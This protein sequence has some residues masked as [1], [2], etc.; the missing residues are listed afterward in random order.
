M[1]VCICNAVTTCQVAQAHAEGA[2]S[3]RH[4]REQLGVGTCCGKCCGEARALL[5]ELSAP[6]PAAR[7]SHSVL[8]VARA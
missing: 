8:A 1:Y 7:A 3:L 4:L 5:R 2:D 6:P